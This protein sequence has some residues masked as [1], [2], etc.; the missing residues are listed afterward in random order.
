[1]SFDLHQALQYLSDKEGSD[2]H[3]K[4]GSPPMV[5]ISGELE[6]LPDIPTLTPADTEEALH[7]IL[8]NPA[9]VQE[10]EDEGEVDFASAIPGLARFRINAFRQ[11]GSISFVCRRIPYGITTIEELG[12]PDAVR[13]TAEEPR[14]IVLVTGTTGSGK[15]TTLAAMVDHVNTTQP[16]HIVTIEDPIEF[17][18]SD[19]RSVINQREVGSDT[20]SFGRALRRVLRQDPDIILIGEMRDEETVRTALSA[21]ETGHLV[22]STLHTADASET[23][24]RVIDFFPPHEHRQ[25]RAMLAATL[26][27]VISQRLVPAI[28]GGRV[29]ALEILRTTG[30]VRDAIIDPNQTGH[31]AQIIAEGAYYGMQTFDQALFGQFK[32]G[33]ITREEALAMASSPQDFKLLL[34]AEGRVGTSM[35][36]LEEPSSVTAG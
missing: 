34:A 35:Q 3:V 21:A 19:K 28:G 4:V 9:R 17:L 13:A 30:R 14:G 27:G 22:L 23:V 1:M 8:K 5:R 12:L 2:L 7:E 36:D 33:N 25:V 31:L 15:S 24:N 16:R 26:R 11:R 32:E 6:P 10:L 20:A 18:H 29:A